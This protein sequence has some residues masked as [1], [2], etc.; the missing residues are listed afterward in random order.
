MRTS[1][2]GLQRIRVREALRLRA[3]RD[4]GGVWTIGYGETRMPG[5]RTVHWTDCC[6]Q[7]E[8]EAW[9]RLRVEEFEATVLAALPMVPLNQPMFDALVSMAYNIG[10]RAFRTSTLVRRLNEGRWIEAQAEFDRWVYDDGQVVQG[11]INRR[12]AEQ[13]DFNDG[14]RQALAG[15]PEVL[16]QFNRYVEESNA[17]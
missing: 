2:A 11:L 1:E 16:A 15:Q 5:G 12:N 10:S 9:L 7:A 13:A 3:Y 8:A 4:S 14:I 6:T 17:A